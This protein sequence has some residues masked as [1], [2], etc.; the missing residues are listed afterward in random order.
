MLKGVARADGSDFP[1]DRYTAIV[2]LSHLSERLASV[3]SKK[4]FVI[5]AETAATLLRMSSVLIFTKETDG[6]LELQAVYADSASEE[7]VSASGKIAQEALSVSSPLLIPN[8]AATSSTA[9]KIIQR[10][11]VAS[12]IC[13]P[14]RIGGTALGAIVCLSEQVRSF[15]P[16]DIELLHVIASHAAIAAMRTRAGTE[17]QTLPSSDDLLAL[18]DRKIRELSLLNQISEAMNSTLELDAVLDIAL[19]E[20]LAAIDADAGSLMLINEDTGKLEIAAS[21]GLPEELVESTSQEIGQSI[22]GWVAEH[23]ESVLV[24]DARNDD[25]FEMPFYRDAITS[26]A[27]VPLKSRNG[28]I[29]VLNVNTTR[30]DRI[31]D[32]R[33]LQFLQTIANQMAAAIQNA[34][35]Y[36]RVRRRTQQ[37]DGLLRVSRSVTSTLSLE[38]RLKLLSEEMCKLLEF[39]VCV[40][41]LV[42]EI[43]G[44]LRHG[45]GRGLRTRYRFTYYNLANPLAQKVLKTRRTVYLKDINSSPTAASDVSKS[46]RLT[47]ALGL[48]LRSN[49]RIVAV[50]TLFARAPQELPPSRRAALKMLADLAG[51]AI[52][53]ALAYQNKYRVASLVQSRLV[54]ADAPTVDGLE[55][56]HKFFSVREVGGDYYDFIVLNDRQIGIVV[57]D[58]SGSDVEAAEHTAMSRHV[59]RAYAREFPRPADVLY[60]TNNVICELTSAETF[61][62]AFYCVI[63]LGR[64]CFT[65]A[66]AGCEPPLLYC[67]AHGNVRDLHTSGVLLG[68]AAGMQYAEQEVS[69]RS[70]DVLVAFT[71]GVTEASCGN[72]RFGTDAVKRVLSA[73]AHLGAQA[74]ADKL[75][76]AIMEF[77]NGKVSDDVAV[78][79]AKRV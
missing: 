79:V 5:A 39:D 38:D 43:T 10:N 69:F 30:P 24:T 75:F 71:D 52:H 73:N 33:D 29:G 35:L 27:S 58:V 44:R 9:A 2:A 68:V 56:G 49:G 19:E 45:V 53:N 37:L 6:R 12:L 18:A 8:T 11:G 42:D 78:V 50:A 36:T 59:I 46:E 26:S 4:A 70:K 72:S 40:I 21:R 55:I 15:S 25:R 14:M 76:D 63:D 65:H 57:A 34:R 13:V 16:R 60:K 1:E 62:S 64:E 51:V 23:G 22:A 61:V 32:E 66:N 67:A 74:I 41:F 28:C 47:C 20:C 77:T 7:L 17:R 31:F 48:P 3:E 54:P